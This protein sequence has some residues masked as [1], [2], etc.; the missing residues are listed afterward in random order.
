MIYF[1]ET[2][3]DTTSTAHFR[4]FLKPGSKYAVSSK[5]DESKTDRGGSAASRAPA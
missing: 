1:T 5:K 4:T 2:T 3:V